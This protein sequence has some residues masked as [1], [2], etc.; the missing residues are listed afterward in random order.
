MMMEPFK[1]KYRKLSE[2]DK[3]YFDKHKKF[4]EWLLKQGVEFSVMIQGTGGIH[5]TSIE[6][7]FQVLSDEENAFAEYLKVPV[8]TLRQYN[9]SE[10]FP[11]CS[12]ITK[13]GTRCKNGSQGVFGHYARDIKDWA[14]M[15][16][17]YC[18][19]HEDGVPK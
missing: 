10:G 19:L 17:Q 18:T 8:D 15:D 3:E 6:G 2:S 7:I 14:E 16:G 11:R 4:L 1:G 12:A 13:K 9:K 5:A